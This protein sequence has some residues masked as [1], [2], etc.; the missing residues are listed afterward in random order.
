MSK[1]I[2]VLALQGDFAAH[3]HML[4]KLGV[5]NIA[6]RKA[7]ELENLDGLIIPG[8]E[9]TTLIK[10]LQSFEWIDPIKKFYKDGKGLFGTCAGSILLAKEIEKSDQFRFGFIDSTVVRNGYGRQ[11]NSFEE[12]IPIKEFGEEPIHAIF[13]RAPKITRCGKNVTVLA[14]R[15]NSILFAREKNVLV[16]TFHPELTDDVRIHRYF[17]DMCVIQKVRI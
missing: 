15:D 17:L 2:G 3:Q 5:E 8:G 4:D 14:E 10:L 13:I 16:S 7:D 12:D 11:A 9:S 1:R 6:V